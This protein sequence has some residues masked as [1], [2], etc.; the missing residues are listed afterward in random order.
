MQ[1][2][3]FCLGIKPFSNEVVVG[4]PEGIHKVMTIHRVSHE[5]RRNSPDFESFRGL[6]WN[7][8]AN[9]PVE[10]PAEQHL[11]PSLQYDP[12]SENVPPPDNSKEPVIQPME[13]EIY[14]SDFE[15]GFGYTPNCRGCEALALR[16][17]QRAHSIECRSRIKQEL[18]K[19]EAGRAR[20][21]SAAQ[22]NIAGPRARGAEASAPV[23]LDEEDR[24]D[25]DIPAAPE[26]PHPS[27]LPMEDAADLLLDDPG[28]EDDMPI[29]FLAQIAY[30]F[31]KYGS[32][33]AEV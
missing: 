13:F 24:A 23:K 22:R 32:H 3:D 31:I 33:T 21:E 7:F 20:V 25:L 26:V 18:L 19:S 10:L 9:S 16:K 14:R 11:R 27:D 28:G 15:N 30:E 29:G 12:Q 4:A 6:P 8:E 5:R 2:Q 1:S 17:G